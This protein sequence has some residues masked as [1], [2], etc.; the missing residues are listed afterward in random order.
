MLQLLISILNMITGILV[1]LI[2]VFLTVWKERKKDIIER[3]EERADGY[4]RNHFKR[5]IVIMK[6]EMQKPQKI[7]NKGIRSLETP[8]VN[9]E[10]DVEKVTIGVKIDYINNEDLT[11]HVQLSS[12]Y[13]DLNKLLINVKGLED[14]YRKEVYETLNCIMRDLDEIKNKIEGAESVETPYESVRDFIT[15]SNP[16]IFYY[17]HSIIDYIVDNIDLDGIDFDKRNFRINDGIIS[18]GL[19]FNFALLNSNSGTLNNTQIEKFFKICENVAGNHYKELVE[20]QKKNSDIVETYKNIYAQFSIIIHTFETGR[21]LEG[22]CNT[23]KE[24][25]DGRDKKELMAYK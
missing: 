15:R 11:Q 17:K 18:R 9:I 5:L 24:I 19:P 23:C 10:H 13:N 1:A 8:G 7:P 12:S 25:E 14:D 4:K 6:N 16:D 2:A 3:Y 21:T 22:T 20:L